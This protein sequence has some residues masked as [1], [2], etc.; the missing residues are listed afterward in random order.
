V[1]ATRAYLQAAN[2][3]E[4]AVA[5][6]LP[7]TRA[8][9]EAFA[10]QVGAECV[11][12][13]AGA[14]SERSPSLSARE[15]GE[16][17]RESE[18][19]G[20][21]EDELGFALGSLELQP[22]RQA[23]LALVSAVTPLSWS[24]PT[25]TRLVHMHVAEFV[26]QQEQLVRGAPAV[27]A[28]I[29]AWVS[30]G[31]E[32]LSAGT[33]EFKRQQ[34]GPTTVRPAVPRQSIARLLAP[35]EGPEERAIVRQT[36]LLQ[37]QIAAA[38]RSL[39]AVYER[40]WRA[41]GLKPTRRLTGE[42]PP[43]GSV[44]IGKGRTASGGSYV[45]TLQ[46]AE[47]SGGARQ[48]RCKLPITIRG[49]GGGV[50][51]CLDRSRHS[52]APPSVGC[53]EGLLTIEALM[54][55]GALHVRLRLSDGRQITSPVTIV[56]A[57]RGGSADGVYYQV[58][59]GPSPIPVSLAELDGDGRTLRVL[60]LP[61]VQHCTKPTLKF[62]PGGLRKVVRGRVPGGPGFSIVGEHYSFLGRDYFELSIETELGGGGESPRG[63]RPGL[64]SWHLWTGCRPHPYMILYGL[65][66]ASGDS[67]YARTSSSSGKLGK[68]RRVAIPRSLHAG[69]VLVYAV[70]STVPSELL[71]RAQDGRTILVESLG[72][73]AAEATETCQGEAEGKLAPGST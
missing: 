69:G 57:G 13:L 53:Y 24:S 2:L 4:Q 17:R 31:Y 66:K 37:K 14:P 44:V 27:C 73:L 39:S 19:L 3:W 1:A 21:L 9:T 16:H 7:A 18:Q 71:V 49:T 67:V 59:R 40:L 26:E 20:D 52:P 50:S 11:G 35:Y 62:L 15:F 38:E 70:S 60:R 48:P 58:V 10:Q 72:D 61:R 28:D 12:A 33:K 54:P 46:P 43:S 51:E 55:P 45:V 47:S 65:L 25:L 8:A 42:E 6:N 68:L 23:T 34:E 64:F 41:V 5:A 22:D 30:S 29:K 36:Q 63:Q 56:P 32:T